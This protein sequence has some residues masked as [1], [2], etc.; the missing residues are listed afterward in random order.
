MFGYV[1]IDK[2]ELKI[3]DFDVYR[4]FYCGL[5]RELRENHGLSGQ[6]SL[7]YDMT[8]VVM[9]LSGLYEPPTRKGTTRCI[10]HPVFR[11]PV[12]KNSA[13]EYGADMNVLL[14]YYKCMDD[15]KDENFK[16]FV[17]KWI[18]SHEGDRADILDLAEY[19]NVTPAGIRRKAREHG[20]EYLLCRRQSDVEREWCD[21]L[22]K[23][24]IAFVSNDRTLI[25]PHEIDI[26]IPEHEIGLEINP[27]ITHNVDLSIFD[28]TSKISVK[29]HQNK[30]QKAEQANINL[31]HVFDWYDNNKMKELVLGLCH[32]NER[33]FARKTYVVEVDAED[34]KAFFEVNHLQGYVKSSCCYGLVDDKGGL[35][36]VMSFA[37]PRYGNKENAEWELLRFA[38]KAGI[39][40]VGGA[41]KLFTHFVREHKPAT[42]MSFCNYDISNGNMYEQ[43]GFEYTRTTLPSY[44][45]VKWNDS[46]E[47]YSWYLINAKGVDNVFGTSYGKD[48]SNIDLM[49]DM[50]YVR[51]YNA[52]N[53]VYLWTAK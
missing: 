45:W 33:V 6:I 12:R 22:T 40:V 41:S 13:T 23:Q 25:A 34:E 8:F 29:Y 24:K 48:A 9:L 32:R 50:G 44:Y 51:V 26:Y 36:A 20:I 16:S 18:T 37:V 43:L 46:T 49:L 27:S 7:T 2:P 52:G 10:V 53:K 11:Q 28:D 5:C 3:K 19:F 31:V 39:T 15:W 4:S 42:V 38:N 30:S 1:T 21:W 17:E 35:V 14:T 47:W